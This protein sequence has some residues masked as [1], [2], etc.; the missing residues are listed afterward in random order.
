MEIIM[1]KRST[2]P[3]HEA[4]LDKRRR[5]M[6][7]MNGA[8]RDKLD[9]ILE[10]YNKEKKA[11]LVNRWELGN[12]I[13]DILVDQSE[14]RSATYGKRAWAKIK[15]FIDE[16]ESTL[17]HTARLAKFYTEEEIEQI[18]KMTMSDGSTHL[19]YSHLRSLAALDN[20]TQRDELLQLTLENCWTSAQLGA[21]VKRRNGRVKTNNPL[22][23]AAVPKDAKTLIQQQI[24][25]ADDFEK[26][27]LAVWGNPTRSLSAQMQTMKPD[28]YTTEFANQLG[29]LAHRMRQLA[30]EAATRADEADRKYKEITR[31]LKLDKTSDKVIVTESDSNEET[32]TCQNSRVSRSNLVSAG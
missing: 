27:N 20:K 17:R 28:D 11:S 23:R 22:G 15:L 30:N 32:S 7:K 6:E 19:S 10:W 26:R 25:F 12:E 29:N 9:Y 13:K 24:N 18:S 31:I 21:E 14:N 3:I 16:D 8:L 4:L 2:I 1:T 5:A